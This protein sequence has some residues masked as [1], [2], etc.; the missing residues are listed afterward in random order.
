M[1]IRI[2]KSPITNA[3]VKQRL[4]AWLSVFKKYGVFG[5]RFIF[6]LHHISSLVNTATGFC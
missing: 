3:E 5:Y 6:I 2:S 4:A 1:M